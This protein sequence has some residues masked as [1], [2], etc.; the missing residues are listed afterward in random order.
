MEVGVRPKIRAGEG[1]V[2]TVGRRVH[3]RSFFVPMDQVYRM[4]A[5]CTKPLRLGTRT[6]EMG[7]VLLAAL[8]STSMSMTPS[9]FFSRIFFFF[10][11]HNKRIKVCFRISHLILSSSFLPGTASSSCRVLLPSLSDHRLI[12]FPNLSSL[13]LPSSLVVTT[14]SFILS[15]PSLQRTS[16]TTAFCRNLTTH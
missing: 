1:G 13:S 11:I 15:Q 10:A 7:R 16:Q 3:G 12:A 6:V 8:A 5:R 9:P 14:V 2:C 4:S